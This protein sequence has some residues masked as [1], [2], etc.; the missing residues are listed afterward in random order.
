MRADAIRYT[1]NIKN[2]LKY[3]L[4]L[5]VTIAGLVLL[6]EFTLR[7][8][9]DISPGRFD[10]IRSEEGVLYLPDLKIKMA[11]GTVPYIIK[12]NSLGFR[13]NEISLEK[14]D[15]KT[16]IAALG[17]SVTDGFFV[18]NQATYPFQLEEV[19]NSRGYPAEVI[20][21]A[22]GGGAI[23]K[24]YAILRDLVRPLKP[25][26]ALLTF[27]TNDIYNIRTFSR[28]ELVSRPVHKLEQRLGKKLITMTAI[29]DVALDMYLRMK[30]KRYRLYERDG[31]WNGLIENRYQIKGGDNFLENVKE[32]K[33]RF[34]RT[35]GLVLNEPFAEKVNRLI[36]N[37][38]F[39]L[40]HMNGFCQENNI[41]LIFIYFPAYP[42]IYDE[43]ASMKIVDILRNRCNALSVP[44]LD[45]TP[46]FRAGGTKKV[47]HLAPLDYHLNPKGNRI[48]AV[49]VADFLTDNNFVRH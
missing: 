47:F 42:Q 8:V 10:F 45:L 39:A 34:K 44:F 26:I 3:L 25:D 35:D 23:G 16:R 41:K 40:A 12:T 4:Y 21:A 9:M 31:G 11:F 22:R 48:F 14:P 49:A 24:E 7:I 30:Y 20:N 32:F 46:A 6:L 2:I 1:M 27:V 37:Y 15:D 36:D 5:T 13:G 33:R 17:D 19:L 29:G 28:A 18:D 43:N 38:L